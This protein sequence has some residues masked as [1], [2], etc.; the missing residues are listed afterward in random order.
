MGV[1]KSELELRAE[2]M[3]GLMK[4]LDLDAVILAGNYRREHR[5][6]V[7]WI[8]D[9]SFSCRY[10]YAAISR[11][12]SPE[13][14]IPN[15][16]SM[17]RG[18]PHSIPS[19]YVRNTAEGIR[20][21]LLE[22]HVKDRV[23]IVG[24]GKVM[25]INEYLFLREAF[26]SVT[27]VDVSL[28]FD[29]L[30]ACKSETELAGLRETVKILEACFAHLLEIARPG[31][32]ERAIGAEMFKRSYELGGESHLLLTMYGV[33]NAEGRMVGSF[34]PPA[35]RILQPGELFIFS[36]ELMGPQG[37]FAEFSRM[38]AMGDGSPAQER[39]HRAVRA[40]MEAVVRTLRPGATPGQV[41]AAVLDAVNQQGAISS[42]WSG[43][44]IGLDL[45]ENPWVGLEV[46]EEVKKAP[47]RAFKPGMAVTIHPL[48]TDKLGEAI[49]YMADTYIVTEEEGKQVSNIDL[50]LYRVK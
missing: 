8:S 10:G 32:S 5:G 38:V 39:V 7:R 46:V 2:R 49:G 48:V 6:A 26:P 43:H 21:Y 29:Q 34:G 31:V 23:G 16:L 18:N 24:L 47:E 25:Q 44:G 30:R 37:Y 4:E 9:Y 22:A 13:L 15:N 42:Y 1:S 20:D 11:D 41:Q 36:Y 14:I 3:R 40:G 35:E 33:P 45:V 19:R 12:R 17:D 50:G 27:F 28:P